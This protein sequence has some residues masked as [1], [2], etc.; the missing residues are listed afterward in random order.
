MYLRVS[1]L[2][3]RQL[4]AGRDRHNKQHPFALPISLTDYT[5][6]FIAEALAARTSSTKE[7]ARG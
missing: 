3:K 2:L 1:P 7:G 6:M 5:V 4:E